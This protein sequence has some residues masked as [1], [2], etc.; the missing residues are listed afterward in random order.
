MDALCAYD[1]HSS[2][3]S[4]ADYAH[5]SCVSPVHK[6]GMDTAWFKAQKKL[7]KT[8][9]QKIADAIGRDRSVITKIMNGVVR[10]DPAF[11]PGFAEQ[12]GVSTNE[13]L[14]RAGILEPVTNAAVVPFEGEA[15]DIPQESLPVWGSALG[16]ERMF[17]GEAVEQTTLNSGD[18][19][20]Y[21]KRPALLNGKR[22]AY[23]LH[24][25]GS[26]MHPALPE[27]EMVAVC[28]DM[29]LSIGDTVVV[30]LRDAEDDGQR[31][32]AVLVKELVR[33]S[34]SYVELRQYE[35]RIDF[36]V[37]TDHVL[38]IDRVLTRKEMLS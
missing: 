29:P 3:G 17:D 38:R 22:M 16:T 27:G 1:A 14:E 37:P 10:F 5:D 23:A 28:R 18:V 34:A 36:K 19:M 9:D 26:S 15:L 20:E 21:V 30:Y 8:N 12:L 2:S 35:P 32:R 7:A 24:V 4:C 11:A 25:Q 6:A 13:V 31:A 33:R